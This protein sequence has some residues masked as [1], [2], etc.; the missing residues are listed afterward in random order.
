M[1]HNFSCGDSKDVF[2]IKNFIFS[3]MWKM[4][5]EANLEFMYHQCKPSN[6][7]H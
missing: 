1:F 7:G 5:G 2:M 3:K 4:D 6:F